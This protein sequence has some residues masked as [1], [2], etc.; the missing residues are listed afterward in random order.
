MF[1][2]S[3]D[4]DFRSDFLIQ[5]EFNTKNSVHSKTYNS[6]FQVAKLSGNFQDRVA[7][8]LCLIKYET[9]RNNISQQSAKKK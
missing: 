9:E 2:S 4:T 8:D 1:F 7:C 5:K 6:P 3:N